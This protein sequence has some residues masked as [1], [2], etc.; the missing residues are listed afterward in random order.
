MCSSDQPADHTPLEDPAPGWTFTRS[1]L[2]IDANTGA[3]S[4]NLMPL[5]EAG[6]DPDSIL[7]PEE[8][9]YQLISKLFITFRNCS[10]CLRFVQFNNQN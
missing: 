9:G 10:F 6:K 4:V 1:L 2:K 5:K 8:D 7:K 3:V